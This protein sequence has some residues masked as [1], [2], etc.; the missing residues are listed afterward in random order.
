VAWTLAVPVI[1]VSA[2]ALAEGASPLYAALV[3]LGAGLAAGLIVGVVTSFAFQ[4]MP[5]REDLTL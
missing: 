1:A 5:A 4:G 3:A 2:R